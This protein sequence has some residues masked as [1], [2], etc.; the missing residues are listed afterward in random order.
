MVAA[1]C[2]WQIAIDRRRMVA[3][4]PVPI[5]GAS[6][7]I[8]EIKLASMPYWVGSNLRVLI[9][10]SSLDLPIQTAICPM[11]TEVSAGPTGPHSLV[12][13]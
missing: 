9:V 2:D 7:L 12:V 3:L 8:Y 13:Y 6:A 11:L 10:C 4:A 5:E 1:F